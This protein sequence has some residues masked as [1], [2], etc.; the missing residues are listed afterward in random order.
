MKTTIRNALLSLLL[1][2]VFGWSAAAAQTEPPSFLLVES[3]STATTPAPGLELY[4]GSSNYALPG[5]PEI[6]TSGTI[7][8]PVTGFAVQAEMSQKAASPCPAPLSDGCALYDQRGERDVGFTVGA[9]WKPLDGLSLS[10][11]YRNAPTLQSGLAATSGQLPGDGFSFSEDL[12]LI[13]RLDTQSWGDLELGL[14]LSRSQDGAF[15][16]ESA[17]IDPHGSAELGLGWQLGAFRGDLT[18]RYTQPLLTDGTGGWNSFDI[19]IAWRTPWN[20]S[21]SV[22]ARNFLDERAPAPNALQSDDFLGRVPY[23]R[24][25]QDL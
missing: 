19:N 7:W 14:Q 3:K 8:S 16:S 25:Q 10:L 15:R 18:G 2:T 12:S 5:T 4:V 24:Y 9:H 22:G 6:L 23:V 21:L 11:N 17:L 1:L 20:A 13:C